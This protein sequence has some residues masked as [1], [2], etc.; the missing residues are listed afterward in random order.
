MGEEA[1]AQRQDGH[2][3]TPP[4]EDANNKNQEEERRQDRNGEQGETQVERVQLI[5]QEEHLTEQT[6]PY[7]TALIIDEPLTDAPFAIIEVIKIVINRM[8]QWAHNEHDPHQQKYFSAHRL[9][10]Q[11]FKKCLHL[12]IYNFEEQ[13]FDFLLLHAKL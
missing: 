4:D 12:V 13:L 8:N 11:R 6:A 3:P 2:A 10:S 7:E 9:A 5:K 1:T